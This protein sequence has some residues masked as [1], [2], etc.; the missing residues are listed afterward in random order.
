M[1]LLQRILEHP[2][3][4]L[5]RIDPEDDDHFTAT[6]DGLWPIHIGVWPTIRAWSVVSNA[7]SR[8]HWSHNIQDE[9]S[10]YQSDEELVEALMVCASAY[11][12]TLDVARLPNG[13]LRLNQQVGEGAVV[14]MPQ[15]GKDHWSTFAYAETVVV[16]KRG[17]PQRAKMRASGELHPHRVYRTPMGT[18]LDAADTPTRLRGGILLLGHDDWSC[19]EDAEH[20]GLIKDIG[21]GMHPRWRLTEAGA[22]MAGLLRH[23][24]AQ[25]GSFGNFVPKNIR[26]GFDPRWSGR[27]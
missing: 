18:V 10:P 23:H 11:W 21:T 6:Y 14:P 1:T 8:V 4:R 13:Q 7:E 20:V 3:G 16:D 17:E 15:W 22:V 12:N 5:W 19:I 9:I 2:F 26:L 25:G 24:K 27:D